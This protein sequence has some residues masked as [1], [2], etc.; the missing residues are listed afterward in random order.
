MPPS[1]TISSTTV[2][3]ELYAAVTASGGG[4]VATGGGATAVTEAV[5]SPAGGTAGALV[6]VSGASASPGSLSLPPRI[7]VRTRMAPTSNAPIS[8]TWASG[9]PFSFSLIERPL[10]SSASL[11]ETLN[12]AAG[13]GRRRTGGP[14]ALHI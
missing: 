13:V 12:S 9:F 8:A 11:A 3:P 10:S 14:D 2:S 7:I 6:A 1:R 5:G 4:E